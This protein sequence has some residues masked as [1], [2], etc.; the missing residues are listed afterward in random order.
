MPKANKQDEQRHMRKSCSL[1]CV[2][3]AKGLPVKRN[4]V[5]QRIGRNLEWPVENRNHTPNDQNQ[6]HHCCD[7]HDLQGLLARFMQ[8]LSILPPE[9]KYDDGCE[10]CRKRIFGESLERVAC[11]PRQILEEACE[12]VPG[13]NGTQGTGQY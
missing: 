1:E 6:A 12:I 13:N 3:P 9:I 7:C 11:I 8:T 2:Q 5:S 4:S 10:S